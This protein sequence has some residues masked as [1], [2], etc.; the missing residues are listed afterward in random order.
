MASQV[1]P[2]ITSA[3]VLDLHAYWN[4]IRAGRF[5]PRWS[6]VQPGDIKH[7]LPYLIVGQVEHDP[8][9]LRYRIVGTAVVDAF[10][11]D[12]TGE[13]LRSPSPGSDASS[14][15]GIY[16]A[17]VDRRAPVF[18]QYRVPVGLAELRVVD[19]GI[20]PL[21]SD[22]RAVDRLIELEDWHAERGFWPRAL[23]PG[24]ADFSLL[25]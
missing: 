5:A 17:F 12:F 19:V 14:W 10:G 1:P 25:P 13:S 9:D 3:L 16:R 11:F 22:G 15:L 20:F 6:D 2:A 4:R 7:L 24:V 21:S 18:G 23:R 8:F